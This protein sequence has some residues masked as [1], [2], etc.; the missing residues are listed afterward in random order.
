MKAIRLLPA[1]LLIA[2]VS[3]A[4]EPKPLEQPLNTWVKRSPLKGGP[5]SPSLAYETSYGYDPVNKLLIR[6]AGHNQGGGGEQNGETWV[7]NPVTAEWKIKEPNTSPPGACCNNQNVF[8]TAQNRFVRFPAFSGSHGWHWFRENYHSNSSLWTYDLTTNTWRN[9]RPMPAPH[10]APLRCA[11]WDSD[12]Q[13]AVVFGGEGAKY[14]TIVYDPYTNTWTE[15]KPAKGPA[16]RSGGNL[17][18]DV[19][20]KVHILFGSQFTDDP[21]TWAYDLRK[22]EWKD[23]KPEKL[24]PTDRNDPVLA[25]DSAN[26]VVVAVVQVVDKSDGKEV[27]GGH[28]ETW[29]YDAGKNTWTPMKPVKE[30]DGWGNRRRVMVYLPDHNLCLLEMYVNPT[31][32]VSGVEREQQ[33]WTYRYAEAKPDPRP[34]PPTGV[35]VTTSANGVTVDWQ[36]SPSTNVAGYVVHRGEGAK[37]WLVDYKEVGKVDKGTTS[38][39]D[40]NLKP[41]TVYYYSVRAVAADK[42][43]SA[44][45]LKVRT[46][47][48]LVEDIVVSMVSLTEARLSWAAPAGK[49]IVGY[50]VER[51]PVEVFSDDQVKRLKTDTPPLEQPSVGTIKAMGEFV[52]LTKEPLKDAKYVDISLNLEKP[53]E[54]GKDALFTHRFAANQLE[55]DGK[56]YRYSVFAY[57]IRAVN[58]LGVEGGPSP[59]F[60]T[61][62]AAPQHVFS[63]EDGETC[64]L[65]WAANREEKLKGYRVYRME[66]PRINGAGQKVTRVTSDPISEL[67]YSDPQA[68]KVTRR[69]WIVAVDA[70]GQEGGPSAPTWF[71]R[72]WKRFYDPF[73][74]EWHQ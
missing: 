24:P 19:A 34:L 44:D 70:L 15:M 38:F 52:K 69:Y 6:W 29:A 23:L 13:V 47:P 61:I 57:R 10:P 8:D 32:R 27:V 72:E 58:V 28:H 59:Y 67:K 5:T 62:P 66:S 39:K 73:V 60:L 22:N 35:Q 45:S 18:Y 17:A 26:Q 46:Q 2:S 50:H 41:G 43:E 7:F 63:K 36:A 49:D 20:R 74:G 33:I 14:G 68:G 53:H 40:G 42:T 12:A 21:H 9:M 16:E 37:P 31:L 30:P 65:R 11:A 56:P 4:A 71:Q 55:A 54:V 1:F 64:Q 3:L 25:Y 51:A 48:R